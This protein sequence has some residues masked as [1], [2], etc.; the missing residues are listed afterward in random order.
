VA[1]LLVYLRSMDTST[2]TITLNFLLERNE[3]ISLRK[4]D[5]KCNLD[6][7]IQENRSRGHIVIEV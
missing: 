7:D 6:S 2:S 3:L 1:S 4:L 5:E